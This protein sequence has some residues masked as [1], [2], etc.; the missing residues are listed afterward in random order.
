VFF[1]LRI[2]KEMGTLRAHIH[3]IEIKH[4]VIVKQLGKKRPTMQFSISTSC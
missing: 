4:D 1:F 2:G 3:N